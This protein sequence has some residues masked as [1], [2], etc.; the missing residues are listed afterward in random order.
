MKN[1]LTALFLL[2]S[3][4][5]CDVLR[6]DGEIRFDTQMDGQ[7]EITL[8]TTGL[9]IGVLPSSNLSV[10]GN[11][12]I[13]EQLFVGGSSG[14]SNL[15][16]N[17][18]IGY[19]VQTVSSNTTLGDY[20]II[21]ADTSSDNITL[22][23]PSASV[24]NGK[25]FTIKKTSLLNQLWVDASDNID[26]QDSRIELTYPD[27]G[28]SFSKLIS[29]GSEWYILNQSNDVLNVIGAD[30][31]VGWWKLD[32]TSGTLISDSSQNSNQGNLM[33]MDAANIGVSGKINLAHDFDGVNDFALITHDDSLDVGNFV[34]VSSWVNFSSLPGGGANR[35]TIFSTRNGNPAGGWQLEAGIGNGGTNRV[36]LTS[37]GT[38]DAYTNNNVI[39]TNTWY[40]IVFT[41]NGT[42]A[43]DTKIYI[44]G[45]SQVLLTD[46]PQVWTDNNNDKFIG[47]GNTSS[48]RHDL[49]GLLDDIR[50][51]NRSLSSAE[52]VVLYNQGH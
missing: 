14:S 42:G 34:S 18:T 27:A 16:V 46:N 3:A 22:T 2:S 13:S 50:L 4:C 41:K 33:N 19:G 45:V 49:D 5:F 26:Y 11:A 32:E 30:N 7:A 10:A 8:N 39:T 52:V 37:R 31:L 12:I 1:I 24:S 17:G 47:K 6:T 43:G 25:V 48:S 9:G 44:N 23:L 28:Y 36:S 40:H 38:W 35:P 29:N 20:S 21:L 15:N 51:Y